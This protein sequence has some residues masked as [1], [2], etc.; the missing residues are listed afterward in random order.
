VYE[1][2]DE[3]LS[4]CF[5]TPNGKRLPYLSGQKAQADHYKQVR[6]FLRLVGKI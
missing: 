5:E 1:A 2:I 6:D 4:L 3:S